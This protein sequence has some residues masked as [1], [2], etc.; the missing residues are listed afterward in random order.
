MNILTDIK[1]C[2]ILYSEVNGKYPKRV[3]LGLK[4]KTRVEEL[5]RLMNCLNWEE[6]P[7]KAYR[8]SIVWTDELSQIIPE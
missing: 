1:D 6:L 3:K 2:F 5:P 4:E 7:K 8:A